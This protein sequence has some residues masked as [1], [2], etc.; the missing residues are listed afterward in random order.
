M[1]PKQDGDNSNIKTYDRG[2]FHHKD[3]IEEEDC[4]VII[5][6]GSSET[7]AHK[8]VLT[9]VYTYFKRMFTHQLEENIS[10]VVK[11]PG[12]NEDTFEKMIKF[13]YTGKIEIDTNNVQSVFLLIDE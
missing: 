4:D 11:L 8:F 1:D 3:R 13:A 12:W 9:S 5:R 10:N 7:R 2:S 6:H